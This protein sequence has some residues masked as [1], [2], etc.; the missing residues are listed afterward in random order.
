MERVIRLRL[1]VLFL[2]KFA[3]AAIFPFMALLFAERLGTGT[4]GLL[5][6]AAFAGATVAGIWAG[7]LAD[8]RGRRRVLVPAEAGRALAAAA[9]ALAVLPETRAAD[10]VLAAWIAALPFLALAIAA[11]ISTPTAEATVI[12]LATPERR[13]QIYGAVYWVTNVARATGTLAGAAAYG[14]WFGWLLAGIAGLA[15]AVTLALA[16]ALVETRPVERPAP[17]RPA[18]MLA[19]YAEVL[20]DRLFLRYAAGVALSLA[21]AA[22][23]AHYV[24]VRLGS[25]PGTITLID[26]SGLHLAL[27]GPGL[28]GLLRIENGLMVVALAPLVQ[29]LARKMSDTGRLTIGFALFAAGFWVLGWSTDAWLLIGFTAL[30]TVGELLYAPPKLALMAALAPE[31]GRSRAA[32]VINL[33]FRLALMTG[34]AGVAA[35]GHVPPQVMAALFLAG[36]LL[37]GWLLVDVARRVDGAAV[38]GR[39][40]GR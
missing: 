29:I 2:E 14:L 3:E 24:A 34:A 10:P 21:V 9:L 12:D 30:F 4:A 18:E 32:A 36:G 40:A 38:P 17:F 26:W 22:Q 25:L 31:A 8:T 20:R 5:I 1:A 6:F 7:H 23:L 11:G 27:D 13:R 33:G 16:L 35:V 15:A 19:G 39:A 37:A 28:F